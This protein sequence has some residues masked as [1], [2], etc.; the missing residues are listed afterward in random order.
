MLKNIIVKIIGKA[1]VFMYI[2]ILLL[3]LFSSTGTLEHMFIY[4]F[5]IKSIADI[6][7]ELGRKRGVILIIDLRCLYPPI[8]RDKA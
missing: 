6:L 8:K 5:Q 7:I 2:F 3:F 4:L 1:R